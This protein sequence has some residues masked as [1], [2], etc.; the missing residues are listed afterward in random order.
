VSGIDADAST[1]AAVDTEL[2]NRILRYRTP[3]ACARTRMHRW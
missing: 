2:T 3:A 1:L